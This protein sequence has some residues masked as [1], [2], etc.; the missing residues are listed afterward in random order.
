[1][2]TLYAYYHILFI[3]AYIYHRDKQR[4]EKEKERTIPPLFYV[5]KLTTRRDPLAKFTQ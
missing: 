4:K 2:P 5:G 1:L 3:E